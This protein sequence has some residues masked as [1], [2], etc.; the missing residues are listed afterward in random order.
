MKV[1]ISVSRIGSTLDDCKALLNKIFNTIPI[2]K[3]KHVTVTLNKS[4]S[5]VTK[6]LSKAQWKR[7]KS[8]AGSD[9]QA[10]FRSYTLTDII[11]AVTPS[12]KG[13]AWS[14]ITARV[15]P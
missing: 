4:F 11:I 10:A 9:I 12:A 1:Q 6:S 13:D 2:V 5:A 3:K 7:L 15:L 14:T 8:T